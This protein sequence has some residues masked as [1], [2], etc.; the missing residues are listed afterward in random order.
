MTRIGGGT[1]DQH[2]VNYFVIH[3]NR[4][5]EGN[6]NPR[7]RRSCSLQ[8]CGMARRLTIRFSPSPS[9]AMIRCASSAVM[10]CCVT[11]CAHICWVICCQFSP[12]TFENENF[13]GRE[14]RSGCW[15]INAVARKCLICSI[16]AAVMIFLMVILFLPRHPANS[17][18]Y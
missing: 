16:P 2:M 8:Q 18:C 11:N 13:R 10:W 17:G 6:K 5:G 7:K 4:L 14:K 1:G 15:R 3:L 12:R 9:R